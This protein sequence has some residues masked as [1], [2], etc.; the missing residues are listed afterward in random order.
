M[1]ALKGRLA[2]FRALSDERLLRLSSAAREARA[3]MEEHV[4]LAT[5]LLTTAERCRPLQSA[6]ERAMPIPIPDIAA[7]PSGDTLLAGPA[8]GVRAAGALRALGAKGAQAAEPLL[9]G[10]HGLEPDHDDASMLADGVTIGG[11]AARAHAPAGITS[12]T[13][14]AYRGGSAAPSPTSTLFAQTVDHVDS[15]APAA[16]ASGGTVEAA[17]GSDHHDGIAA[18]RGIMTAGGLVPSALTAARHGF[19]PLLDGRAGAASST[20]PRAAGATAKAAGATSAGGS[21][22]AAVAA[23]SGLGRN[24]PTEIGAQHAADAETVAAEAGHDDAIMHA[25]LLA[26]ADVESQRLRDIIEGGEAE[27]LELFWRRCNNAILE[28]L[29]VRRAR[30]AAA[31][32]NA[33]LRELLAGCIA[34]STVSD[35]ALKGAAGNPLM[36]VNGRTGI[37]TSAAAAFAMTLGTQAAS[38][39]AA[40]AWGDVARAP[41]ISAQVHGPLR[42]A[43]HASRRGHHDGVARMGLLRPGGMGL[44]YGDESAGTRPAA[45]D[46][47]I[48]VRNYAMQ[49]ASVGG[50]GAGARA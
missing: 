20:S 9:A 29:A 15:E 30:D 43:E 11:I 25:D 44:I 39:A 23:V 14:D 4:A 31:A 33:R 10:H 36:A 1:T 27:A 48:V 22:S 34:S 35:A 6:A 21:Q 50:G 18:A 32:E 46:G 49:G 26:A 17:A 38:A 8:A 7:G 3:Q 16:W 24:S 13:L 42:L 5:R 19:L 41:G 45:V 40:A 2:N 47:G 12:M 28:S 37:D